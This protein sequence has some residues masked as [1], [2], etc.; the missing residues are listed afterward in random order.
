MEGK[1]GDVAEGLAAGERRTLRRVLA[2]TIPLF[3]L[4]LIALPTNLNPILRPLTIPASSM[5][6]LLPAGS[7]AIASR[8]SYGLSRA[9]YDWIQLPISGRLPEL[10][11]KRGDVVVFRLPR[12]PSVL[13]VK[14]VIGLPGDRVQMVKGRLVLNGTTVPREPAPDLPDPTRERPNGGTAAVASYMERL[15]DAPGYRI[16]EM[17]GDTGM[18]DDTVEVTVPADHLF[19][20]GDNRDNSNDSRIGADRGGVGLVPIA[21][22]LGRIVYILGGGLQ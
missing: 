13:Y 10:T 20:L 12:D 19:M 21:L 8:L 16:I 17:A 5:A 11:P 22:V 6:P 18:L 1:S 9:S 14:R 4:L 2:W 15:A 3:L 7:Y